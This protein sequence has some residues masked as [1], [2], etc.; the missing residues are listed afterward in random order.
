MGCAAIS[1]SRPAARPSPDSVPVD[2]AA[3]GIEVPDRIIRRMD[4][5]IR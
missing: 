5:V 2:E 1:A 3:L 4:R